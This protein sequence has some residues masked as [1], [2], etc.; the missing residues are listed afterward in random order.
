MEKGSVGLSFFWQE[1]PVEEMRLFCRFPVT[2]EVFPRVNSNLKT[3]PRVDNHSSGH[4]RGGGG[5]RPTSYTSSPQGRPRRP[6]T[7]T[8]AGGSGGG[9]GGGGSPS[10]RRSFHHRALEIAGPESPKESVCPLG[11]SSSSSSSSAS[12]AFEHERVGAGTG[13][14]AKGERAS[15]A[16]RPSN[17]LRYKTE[18]CR[19]FEENGL[20]RSVFLSWW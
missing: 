4:R 19:T 7:T 8:P 3:V 16:G 20:C 9:G 13:V 11:P 1:L 2:F 14:G 18:L 15:V 17:L 10:Y 12:S 6:S 5:G